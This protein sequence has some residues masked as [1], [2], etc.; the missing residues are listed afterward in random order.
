MTF[1]RIES[2]R[3]AAS[4]SRYSVSYWLQRF[5]LREGWGT[6]VCVLKLAFSPR[7]FI[8]YIRPRHSFACETEMVGSEG[9]VHTHEESTGV[10]CGVCGQLHCSGLRGG[11]HG[12]YRT[13]MH[14]G[15]A[16]SGASARALVLVRCWGPCPSPLNRRSRDSLQKRIG[17]FPAA[18]A[19]WIPGAFFVSD[20]F[21]DHRNALATYPLKSITL[22]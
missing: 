9:V 14:A 3:N 21:V 13:D 8:V 6:A 5:F 11:R 10:R 2:I 15:W 4:F 12:F 17:K 1:S 19:V 16:V 7:S 18:P 20:T 22:L